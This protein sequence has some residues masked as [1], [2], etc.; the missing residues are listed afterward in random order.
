MW[1]LTNFLQA[2][3]WTPVTPIP[4]KADHPDAGT[5][6]FRTRVQQVQRLRFREL[7][8]NAI[9]RM[10]EADIP[11][12]LLYV[13][14]SRFLDV[15]RVAEA[16]GTDTVMIHLP[17]DDLSKLAKLTPAENRGTEPTEPDERKIPPR[18]QTAYEQY[19]QAVAVLNVSEP[20]DREAYDVL[21]KACEQAGE[22][23]DLPSFAT[24]RRNLT[25][26][27][28]R[29]GTQK[30]TSRAGRGD[31]GSRFPKIEDIEPQ[32]LPNQVRPRWA[33]R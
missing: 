25:E 9:R 19:K 13:I 10:Y 5:V 21:A 2:Y 33:D 28:T 14:L 23:A 32:S 20:T 29:T 18:A 4:A 3:T 8:E 1:A 24:W 7:A 22:A 31:S 27:R 12:R 16:S 30:N 17:P 26:Y 15:A 6:Y 11:N